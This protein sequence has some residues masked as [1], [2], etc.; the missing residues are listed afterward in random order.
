M[1]ITEEKLPKNSL[2]FLKIVNDKISKNINFVK[3]Y[4]DSKNYEKHADYEEI[5][6]MFDGIDNDKHNP[7]STLQTIIKFMNELG[8][9]DENFEIL[10][11][12]E[13]NKL[14]VYFI[15]AYMSLYIS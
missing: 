8:W 15:L 12:M 6:Y 5:I 7:N 10:P 14:Y 11:M 13:N 1:K 9:Y 4:S 3:A 2:K